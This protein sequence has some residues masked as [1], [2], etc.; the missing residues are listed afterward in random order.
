[1]WWYAWIFYI[2][3]IF[4]W[5]QRPF[6]E[7]IKL[8]SNPGQRM[9]ETKWIGYEERKIVDE[10]L[11]E[12]HEID[13]EVMIMDYFEPPLNDADTMKS[14]GAPMQIF[15]KPERGLI[16]V[17]ATVS[18]RYIRI[19]VYCGLGYC[20]L[21]SMAYF[22]TRSKTKKERCVSHKVEV[23]VCTECKHYHIDP[24]LYIY[25]FNGYRWATGLDVE[26]A[27]VKIVLRQIENPSN[28]LRI[29]FIENEIYMNSMCLCQI[30]TFFKIFFML[31]TGTP[32]IECNAGRKPQSEVIID[33]NDNPQGWR[34][35]NN[36]LNDEDLVEEEEST[37]VDESTDEIEFIESESSS[38]ET[39]K[40]PEDMEELMANIMSFD[41]RVTPEKQKL[42]IDISNL[43][44]EEVQ[45][46]VDKV[47]LLLYYPDGSP[48]ILDCR[49]IVGI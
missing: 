49:V 31:A 20:L 25:L 30:Q 6:N 46:S 27:L 8:I 36:R 7:G 13:N 24:M 10:P 48:C 4:E 37:Q 11:I 40:P 41:Q 35:E 22:L 12:Q 18:K 42:P 34:V 19:F 3:R 44:I 45:H 9:G 2:F 28:F 32:I 26:N 39:L 33:N 1:M 17:I 38:S 23:Q 15:K 29:S 5:L 14:I 16:S 21:R 47:G 43:S